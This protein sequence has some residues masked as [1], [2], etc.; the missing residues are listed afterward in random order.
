[1]DT[2]IRPAPA[3]DPVRAAPTPAAMRL[4]LDTPRTLLLIGLGLI[5]LCIALVLV[6]V[7]GASSARGGLSAMQAKANEVSATN[8]LY[9]R[10]GDMDAQAADVLLV[11]FHPTIAV[12]SSVDAAASMANYQADRAAADSDLQL[13]ATN[14]ALAAPY[15]NLLDDLGGYEGLVAEAFYID[16]NTQNEAPARPPSAALAL[17]ETATGRMHGDLLPTAAQIT[18]ADVGDVDGAYGGDTDAM[19]GYSW[20]AGLLTLAVLAALALANRS[21]GRRFRRVLAP[22]LLAAFVLAAVV[23]G[24]ALGMLQTELGHFTTAKADAFDSINVLTSARAVSD[25]ANASESRW[26]LDPTPAF[27]RDFFTDAVQVLDPDAITAQAAATAPTT[28]YDAVANGTGTPSLSLDAGFN[29][30]SFGG[31][32]RVEGQGDLG[33]E[34]ANITFP[35]EARAAYDAVVAYNA[36][37]QDDAT[38][39]ED[40]AEGN[41]AAAVTFDVG[42]QPGQSNHDFGVYDRDLLAVI[43]INQSA[44]QAAVSQGTSELGVWD[45]LPFA[46]A[47]ALPV[48]I[49]GAVYPRLREYS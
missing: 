29:T 44:F 21:L 48:L 37:I 25:D 36:Y 7:S 42:L 26:L 12:P 40:A 31:Q 1:M 3:G 30:V 18:K 22:A 32:T 10:L 27:Q 9:F 39:R 20:A 41:L 19:T 8:D 34:L 11:G 4:R 17:Y 43:G 46:L 33:K 49:A 35:G 2:L 47:A 24:S 6:M 45:W 16:Q 14:P 38:I 23:G 13:I 5:A 15:R 28:Y